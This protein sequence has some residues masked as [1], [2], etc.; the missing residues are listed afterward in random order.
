MSGLTEHRMSRKEIWLAE[1]L[2]LVPPSP[3]RRKYFDDFLKSGLPNRREEGWRWTDIE[4]AIDSE[5]VDKSLAEDPFKD[6]DALRIRIS[7]NA[8]ITANR[9]D[10]NLQI[11]AVEEVKPT[12]ESGN[13]SL[14]T[15][16]RALAS[17]AGKSGILGIE[18]SGKV[19]IPIHLVF[20]S[21]GKRGNFN[22]IKVSVAPNASV[23]IIE[24]HLGGSEL[25]STLLEFDIGEGG[26][27][28]RTLF[29]SASEKQVQYVNAIVHLSGKSTFNQTTLAFG[30]K[31]AR[32]ETNVTYLGEHAEARLNAAY[33]VGNGK[34]VDLTS[35]VTHSAQ[36]CVTNQQTKGAVMNGGR[37]VFQGKF[38]VPKNLGQHTDANMQHHALLLGDRAEVF[39]KPE[40]EIYAD[41][42]ACAHGNTCGS[43]DL[44]QLFYLRQRGIPENLARAI[45]TE[46]FVTETY[47]NSTSN[48]GKIL[49]KETRNRLK[50][51]I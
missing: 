15:L 17:T 44:N 33:V 7:D 28:T 45:L 23:E 47:E 29:Q 50:E 9:S 6:I 32:L 19:D 27:I 25:S 30:S 34:H 20:A 40:L 21:T 31:T 2:E 5:F 11:H 10:D 46:A 8:S 4:A 41:D 36:Y 42:V 51:N 35:D 18:V 22:R 12:E 38:F 26:A 48:V 24:S 1:K 3:E 13:S 39:A 49:S 16:T 43:M 14:V 37:G